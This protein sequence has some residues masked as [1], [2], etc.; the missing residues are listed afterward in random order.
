MSTLYFGT[1]W[2]VSAPLSLD[3]PQQRNNRPERSCL[4]HGSEEEGRGGEERDVQ[5]PPFK[6]MPPSWGRGAGL[7]HTPESLQYLPK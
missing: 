5:D 2:R 3:L 4:V 1:D 6:G 7:G